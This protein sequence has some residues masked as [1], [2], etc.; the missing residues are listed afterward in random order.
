MEGEY[1]TT[2]NLLILINTFKIPSRAHISF[3]NY[4]LILVFADVL[5]ARK[6]NKF[7]Y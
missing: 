6:M 5:K 7:I 2:V 4:S 3:I 1:N